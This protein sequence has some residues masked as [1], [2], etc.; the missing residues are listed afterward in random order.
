VISHRNAA[1]AA[2]FLRIGEPLSAQFR[3]P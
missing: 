3:D 1:A 2:L